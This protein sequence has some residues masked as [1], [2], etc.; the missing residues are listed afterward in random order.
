MKRGTVETGVGIFVILGLLCVGYLTIK[1]GKMEWI[2]GKYY[3]VNARFQSV[4][5]LKEGAEPDRGTPAQPGRWEVAR[6]GRPP[7]PQPPILEPGWWTLA[8][9]IQHLKM[10]HESLYVKKGKKL[11][12]IH[13]IGYAIDPDGGAFLQALTAQ[14]KGRYRRVAKID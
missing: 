13:A 9:F 14:Y 7:R 12:V 2:G 10:L 3:T 8:D 4:A 11:P 1:L 6:S 5:G